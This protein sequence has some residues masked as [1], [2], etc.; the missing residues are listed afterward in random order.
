MWVKFD[1]GFA[2]H[3]KVEA[4]SSD[5]FRLHVMAICYAGRYLTDGCIPT[6][7][8]TRRSSA[9][10]IAELEGGRL[11]EP[12]DD[13][14]IIH[15]YCDYNP[16]RSEVDRQRKE[17]QARKDAWRERKVERKRDADGTATERVPNT[18]RTMPRTRT[19]TRTRPESRPESGEESSSL[20][21]EA[22]QTSGSGGDLAAGSLDPPD[23]DHD[24]APKPNPP[25]TPLEAYRAAWVDAFASTS[26]PIPQDPKHWSEA[27]RKRIRAIHRRHGPPWWRALC[28]L[29]ARSDFLTSGSFFDLDWALK[30][31][32]LAKIAEGKYT[33]RLSVDEVLEQGAVVNG[34]H[35]TW[36]SRMGRPFVRW[37]FPEATDLERERFYQRWNTLPSPETDPFCRDLLATNPTPEGDH[38]D[39]RAEA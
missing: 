15:D 31:A 6:A 28:V 24:S 39:V 23:P 20:R 38:P 17:A 26:V 30:P 33:D 25:P 19:R 7:W 16:S 37:R 3:P 4:L 12:T 21:S 13:G 2:D 10:A 1:D 27:R 9:E 36:Q 14:W 29:A 22:P 35:Q 5:A 8:A 34:H 11:W 18:S 32:N